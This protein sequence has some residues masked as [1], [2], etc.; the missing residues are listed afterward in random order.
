MLGD[1]GKVGIGYIVK[2]GKVYYV[3]VFGE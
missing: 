3:Q 2:N 1:W